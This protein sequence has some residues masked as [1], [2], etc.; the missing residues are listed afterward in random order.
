MAKKAAAYM[1]IAPAYVAG[2]L[3]T[4][5]SIITDEDLGKKVVAKK[6]K[7]G[8]PTG[9]KEEVQVRPPSGSISLDEDHKP[10]TSGDVDMLAALASQQ[11]IAAVSPHAPFPTKP[12]A[13]PAQPAGGV[14]VVA[15]QTRAV[16]DAP[17]AAATRALVDGDKG[18][19]AAMTA[20][21][22]T[23]NAAPKAEEPKRRGS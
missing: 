8:K 17:A 15:R 18:T 20:G 7:D 3:L 6:D 11:P 1:L 5:G 13:A 19:A 16:P 10:L 21:V 23:A 12:Q 22:D 9:D 2:A 14:Q 4:A